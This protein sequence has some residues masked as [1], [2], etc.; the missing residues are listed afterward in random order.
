MWS[1]GLLGPT[2]APGQTQFI[3]HTLHSALHIVPGAGL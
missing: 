1:D 3:L 2:P